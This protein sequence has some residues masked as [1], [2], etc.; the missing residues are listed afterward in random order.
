[1]GVFLGCSGGP[2]TAVSIRKSAEDVWGQ[3]VPQE[4]G[5]QTSRLPAVLSL[6]FFPALLV[7]K[8]VLTYADHKRVGFS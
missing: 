2:G 3:S 6:G 7:C 4:K 8:A 1:M 5:E